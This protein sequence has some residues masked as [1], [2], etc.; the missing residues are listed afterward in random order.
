VNL[1]IRDGHFDLTE[2]GTPPTAGKVI[3]ED[4][5]VLLET[6]HIANQPLEVA[7]QNAAKEHP[8]IKLT[9]QEDGS[10]LFDNPVAI[11]GKPV[12]LNKIKD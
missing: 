5:H 12:G 11:D 7:S 2:A 6:T 9:P 10:L 8:I 3:A 4:G 1:V